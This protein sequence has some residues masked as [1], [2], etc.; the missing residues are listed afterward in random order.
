MHSA[1]DYRSEIS[2]NTQRIAIG[3]LAAI[4]LCGLA[5]AETSDRVVKIND[6]FLNGI[7]IGPDPEILIVSLDPKDLPHGEDDAELIQY[8]RPETER[9]PDSCWLDPAPLVPFTL[10]CGAKFLGF[11]TS[12]T[13][14]IFYF[15]LK[16]HQGDWYQVVLNPQAGSTIW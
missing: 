10:D 3:I 14:Q 2:L 5:G 12:G 4:L 6:D 16:A 1:A 7:P 8:L 11:E 13:Q 9:I 15:L